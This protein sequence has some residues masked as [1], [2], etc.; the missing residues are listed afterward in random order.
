MSHVE[1]WQLSG[2]D[3]YDLRNVRAS[4]DVFRTNLRGYSI[5]RNLR[6]VA[7]RMLTRKKATDPVSAMDQDRVGLGPIF[8]PPTIAH[9]SSWRKATLPQPQAILASYMAL[10]SFMTGTEA[11]ASSFHI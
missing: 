10:N 1:C 9:K 2:L 11:A 8:Q 4:L 7:L 3:R 5:Q 6:F